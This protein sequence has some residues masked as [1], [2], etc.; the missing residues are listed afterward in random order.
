LCEPSYNPHLSHSASSSST[1][2]KQCT[3]QVGTSGKAVICAFEST[4]ESD[5]DSVLNQDSESPAM[6]NVFSEHQC[7]DELEYEEV[8]QSSTTHGPAAIPFILNN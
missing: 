4:L 8:A 6:N 7:E 3:S 2:S 5:L 1:T